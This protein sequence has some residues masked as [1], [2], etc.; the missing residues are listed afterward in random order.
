MQEV[1]PP[2]PP[3]F[4]LQRGPSITQLD[5]NILL[6]ICAPQLTAQ[7]LAPV[8]PVTKDSLSAGKFVCSAQSCSPALFSALCAGKFIS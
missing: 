3:P 7:S 1:K 6:C 5:G 4:A 2:T 8:P